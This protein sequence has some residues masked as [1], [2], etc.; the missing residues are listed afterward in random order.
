MSTFS[1]MILFW[2]IFPVVVFF[3]ARFLVSVFSLNTRFRIKAPDL[4]VP[5]LLYGVHKLSQATLVGSII[6][7]FFLSLFSLGIGLAFFQAYFYD[8][9]KYGRYLKMYWRSV[10]LLTVLLYAVLIV[11]SFL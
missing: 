6:P 9:I 3:A 8:E 11:V 2:Y 4:A 7:Y 10:F 5:L 1:P